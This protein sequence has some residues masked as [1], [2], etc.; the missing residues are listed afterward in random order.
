M[1][2][3]GSVIFRFPHALHLASGPPVAR[4]RYNLLE[5]P[6][7]GPLTPLPTALDY[8]RDFTRKRQLPET[9]SAQ[10]EFLNE[11]A[12]PATTF[13][14][15][16]IAYRK[17]FLLCFL[18]NGR[19]SSHSISLSPSPFGRGA[20]RKPNRTKPQEREGSQDLRKLT[21]S[22]SASQCYCLKGIPS[23]FNN[24]RASS[25][26]RAVVTTVTFIPR[27]LSTFSYGIS[28]KIS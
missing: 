15:A 22:P 21:T 9:N 17:L 18:S 19:R 6:S 16:V 4:C 24:S 27:I 3:I 26:L 12:R 13:T 20:K 8:S 11:T 25:S 28:G 14:A 23:C 7:A 10:L 1:S 5:G 2:A